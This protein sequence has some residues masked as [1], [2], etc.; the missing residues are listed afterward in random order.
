MEQWESS[1]WRKILM[2]LWEFVSIWY[3]GLILSSVKSPGM[4]SGGAKFLKIGREILHK[5]FT[6]G[7][8]CHPPG[9]GY[10]ISIDFSDRIQ[11][12]DDSHSIPVW[13]LFVWAWTM[14]LALLWEMLLV[15]LA[16]AFSSSEDNTQCL[17]GHSEL[18][19]I[20]Y[21]LVRGLQQNYPTDLC[22]KYLCLPG[23]LWVF[24]FCCKIELYWFCG[25]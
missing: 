13:I 22:K 25:F 23:L 3:C 1:I 9:F 19:L 21:F 24:F 7:L 17:S 4:Q 5:N 14:F 12:L 6:F 10:R 15:S 8:L 18:K 11:T 2:S 16:T 20:Q